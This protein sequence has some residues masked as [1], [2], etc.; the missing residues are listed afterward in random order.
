MFSCKK[1]WNKNNS[2]WKKFLNLFLF[3]LLFSSKILIELK[4]I[5]NFD[6]FSD[7]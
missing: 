6:I 2:H 4:F 3:E 1:L 7:F 5:I